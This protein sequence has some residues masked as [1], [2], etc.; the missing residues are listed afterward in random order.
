MADL[1]KKLDTMKPVDAGA[2]DRYR[3]IPPFRETRGYIARVMG[4]MR[5]Y[6]KE[7]V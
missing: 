7:R 6:R 2:V 3:G 1:L 5:Q 4:Y